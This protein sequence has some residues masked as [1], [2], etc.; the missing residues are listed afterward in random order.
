[1]CVPVEKYCDMKYDCPQGTDEIDCDCQAWN[2]QPCY[3]GDNKLCIY[4]EWI[5]DASRNLNDNNRS[6]VEALDMELSNLEN[7]DGIQC[8]EFVNKTA[9]DSIEVHSSEGNS[10]DQIPL[11]CPHKPFRC[12]YF[13]R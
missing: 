9:V 13:F 7:L 2:M 12:L 10:Y 1:M 11:I 4:S 5:K 6:C 3:I 8:V